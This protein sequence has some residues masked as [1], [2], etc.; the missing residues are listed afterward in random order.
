[1]RCKSYPI[2]EVNAPAKVEF[3][4]TLQEVA[5]A[6]GDGLAL[7]EYYG[8]SAGCDLCEE[9]NWYHDAVCDTFC[10]ETDPDC[11]STPQDPLPQ[12]EPEPETEPQS[13]SFFMYLEA[14]DENEY[15][16]YGAEDTCGAADGMGVCTPKPEI[17]FET[18]AVPACG[19]DGETYV[20]TCEAAQAGI[21][22]YSSESCEN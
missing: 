19:C 4:Q 14:C 3:Q 11:A 15:C 8:Y 21:S 18:L 1:V 12:P 2:R 20:N 7:C 6:D 5:K 10:I 13:C 9:W 17:C 16:H 22:V